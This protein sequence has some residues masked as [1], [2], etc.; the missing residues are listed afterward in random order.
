MTSRAV[1][2]TLT[3]LTQ[4][5]DDVAVDRAES[6]VA[7]YVYGN[8]LVLAA[9]VGASPSAVGSGTAVVL[10]V[11]TVVSTFVAHVLAHS[12]GALFGGEDGRT[13]ARVALRDAVPILSSGVTP[14]VLLAATALGWL[15][16]PWGQSLSAVVLLGRIA[17]T[18]VVY[19]RLRADVPLRRAWT[20]GVLAAVVAAVAVVL[21]LTLTH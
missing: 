16:G 19:R 18:G 7:A 12:I 2:T 3:T 10:V 13:A 11:G 9:V 15:S 8:V 14:A 6:R 1:R 20:V 17:G 21:K 4:H 5:R